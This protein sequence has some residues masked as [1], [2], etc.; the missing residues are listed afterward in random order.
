[1]T[2]SDDR[3]ATPLD[4]LE[5]IG[6]ALIIAGLLLASVWLHHAVSYAGGLR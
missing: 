5:G 3:D 6:W 4:W 2:P 1:M